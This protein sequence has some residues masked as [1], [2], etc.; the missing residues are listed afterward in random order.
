MKYVWITA[1]F[2][3]SICCSSPALAEWN[4]AKDFS[5]EEGLGAKNIMEFA[6]NMPW[7][8]DGEDTGKYLYVIADAGC[9]ASQKLYEMMQK[10]TK[11]VQTRWIF[12]DLQGEGTYNSLYEERTPEA[13]KE[14][15]LSQMLPA[16]KDPARS[17][18]IDQYTSK[19]VVMMVLSGQIAAGQEHFGYPTL[20]YG[21]PEKAMIST[22]FDPSGLN[23]IIA[24]I[25][26]VSVRENFTP[27]AMTADQDAYPLKPL[28]AGYQYRNKNIEN[29]P[30]YLMPDPSSPRM[31]SVR[32]DTDWGLEC[33]GMTENGFIAMKITLNNGYVYCFDPA[34]TER[35]AK[36]Q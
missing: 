4:A 5:V 17:A 9:S 20:I 14:V 1:S 27:Q 34:E 10:H 19:A 31:G 13:L 24:A 33:V 35:L 3:L 8:A 26:P 2:L 12:V 7:I 29:T 11:D 28:P 23:K 32:P 18:K 22:G 15:F 6:E 25:P 36:E 16:D 21:T 30:Y